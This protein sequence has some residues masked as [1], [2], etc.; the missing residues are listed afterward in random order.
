MDGG[1]PGIVPARMYPGCTRNAWHLYMFRY[2]PEA[3][4]GLP[5]STFVRAL[6][7]E[8]VPTSGGYAP[9]N[10]EPFLK[11]T[12]AARDFQA[13]FSKAR[14]AAWEERNICPENDKLCTEA[15]WFTHSMLLGTRADM[16]QIAGAVRKIQAHAPR[17]LN[18]K[19]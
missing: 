10:R 1:I 4:A 17:L 12:L 13:L 2:Q 8:G 14:I 15:V 7:V 9:L 11:N 19:T 18:L 5:R 16:E 3:F 6:T